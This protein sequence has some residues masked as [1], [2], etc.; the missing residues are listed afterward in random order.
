MSF[1]LSGGFWPTSLPLFQGPVSRYMPR[2]PADPARVKRWLAFLHNHKDVIAAIDFFTVPAVSL[3]VL[4]LLFVI[5]HG[6][7]RIVLFNVLQW[8]RQIA[9]A[10]FATRNYRPCE[11][12]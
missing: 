1:G 11:N 2:R 9:S 12:G 5:D 3:Q 6:R 8:Q 4:Y 7:R 10:S